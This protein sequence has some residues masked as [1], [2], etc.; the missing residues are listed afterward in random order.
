MNVLQQLMQ[1]ANA[2]CGQAVRWP[3]AQ[4]ESAGGTL[5]AGNDRSAEPGRWERRFNGVARL[6]KT[7]KKINDDAGVDNAGGFHRGKASSEINR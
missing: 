2:P 6:R 3:A 7:A 1:A 5:Y 4:A